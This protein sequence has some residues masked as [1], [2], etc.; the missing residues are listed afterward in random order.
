MSTFIFQ[1]YKY[2]HIAISTNMDMYVIEHVLMQVILYC[3][4][5]DSFHISLI[6]QVWN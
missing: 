2:M 3:F 6:L 4:N 1:G 5:W